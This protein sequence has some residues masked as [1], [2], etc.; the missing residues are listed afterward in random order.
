VIVSCY[1]TYFH[2]LEGFNSNKDTFVLLGDSIIKNNAYISEGKSVE[3]ILIE[4]T[5]GKTH[6]YAVDHSKIVDV[7]SQISQIPLELN[8]KNTSIF[9]SAGGNDI[10]TH[11][12]DQEGDITDSTVLNPMFAAYKKLIESIR[13]RLPKAKIYLLDIYY[14]DTI[15]YKPYH[16]IISEW[17]TMIYN[18][19]NNS[20][21][22]I[23]GVVKVSSILTQGDDFAFG[24]E[25]S[26]KGGQKIAENILNT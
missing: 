7:Y 13:V 10:L 16:S 23:S 6:C 17:N 9:L 5:N 25:P 20:K 22:N 14:P 26:S 11:Y 12:V 3:D 21:N 1:T 8:N 4:R 19:A 15:K 18:Y 24:I 2:S